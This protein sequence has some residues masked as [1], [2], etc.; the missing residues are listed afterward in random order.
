M[1]YERP[2]SFS[3]LHA[4]AILSLRRK[5]LCDF[6]TQD[7]IMMIEMVTVYKEKDAK[8]DLPYV[9]AMA[10]EKLE[11]DPFAKGISVIGWEKYLLKSIIDIEPSLWNKHADLRQ[12]LNNAVAR[13]F[14]KGIM[15]TASNEQYE[16]YRDLSK[17]I[18]SYL[19]K[20]LPEE[21]IAAKPLVIEALRSASGTASWELS[22]D[23][24]MYIDK[25]ERQRPGSK[26]K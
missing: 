9:A 20:N 13:I 5:P 11:S 21:M 25:K 3:I 26:S 2:V 15:A 7:L 8:G 1:D 10:I 6:T 16:E 19:D 22:Y 23:A 14:S 18:T 24:L 12:A 17:T 4:G